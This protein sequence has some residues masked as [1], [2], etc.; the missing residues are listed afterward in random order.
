[1]GEGGS[2]ATES[3]CIPG[4]L[5]RQLANISAIVVGGRVTSWEYSQATAA[6]I[7]VA[8]AT[9]PSTP[10]RDSFRSWIVFSTNVFRNSS[11]AKALV[12]PE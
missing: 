9:G 5:A 11:V 1:M 2:Y 6:H 8:V 4:D 3:Q 10:V 12:L 7:T